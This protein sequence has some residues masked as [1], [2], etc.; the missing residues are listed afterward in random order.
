MLGRLPRGHV[1]ARGVRTRL[2]SAIRSP[3]VNRSIRCLQPSAQAGAPLSRAFHATPLFK[4]PASA[5]TATQEQGEESSST[6]EITQFS[7]LGTRGL[8]SQNIVNAISRMGIETMTD[9]QRL[10]INQTLKGNDVYV[11]Q[12]FNINLPSRNV[13]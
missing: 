12:S 5:A 3:L 1:L 10:T 4:Q 8:V 13:C 2:P 6:G 7:E 11:D 9:V